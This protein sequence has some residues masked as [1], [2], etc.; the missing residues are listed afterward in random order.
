MAPLPALQPSLL[1]GWVITTSTAAVAASAA[2]HLSMRHVA[3]RYLLVG[4]VTRA[5]P[6]VNSSTAAAAAA[7]AA[8]VCSLGVMFAFSVDAY[9]SARLSQC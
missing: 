6:V 5:A 4:R 3:R 8:T 1:P 2:Q 9:S 7:V